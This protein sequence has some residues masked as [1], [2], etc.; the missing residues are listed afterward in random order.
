MQC[1][2]VHAGTAVHRQSLVSA[3]TYGHRVSYQLKKTPALTKCW[4]PEQTVPIWHTVPTL[5][6]SFPSTSRSPEYRWCW[7]CYWGSCQLHQQPQPQSTQRGRQRSLTQR[8][9]F[10][11]FFFTVTAVIWHTWL[12]FPRY[13]RVIVTVPTELP[14]NSPHSRGNYRGYRGIT[15]IPITVSTTSAD[16]L[17]RLHNF[18]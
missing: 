15:A 13:Y 2:R 10:Q 17:M 16:E 12:P 6:K 9:S 8:Q 4:W 18:T 5:A 14:S 7:P 11:L 1:Q 3:G